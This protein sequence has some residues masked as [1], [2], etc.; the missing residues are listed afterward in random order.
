MQPYS[1]PYLGYFQLIQASDLF[2]FFD[3]VNYKKKSWINRNRI[4]LNGCPH[5]FTIPIKKASQN[6]LI[7]ELQPNLNSKRKITLLKTIEHA[8]K[9]APYFQETIYIYEKILQEELESLPSFCIRGI[10]Y[11]YEY[12]DL[13]FHYRLSSSISYKHHYSSTKKI[14]SIC[15]SLNGTTYINLPGGKDLYSQDIQQFSNENIKL[16]F[17]KPPTSNYIQFKNK[18]IPNLSIIDILMFNSK[19]KIKEMFNNFKLD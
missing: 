13:P 11:I 9:K 17:L 12:L 3:D 5:L 2:V 4:L 15:K 1:F 19:R 10:E 7:N 8:Y 16:Q 6:S 18:H 14:I